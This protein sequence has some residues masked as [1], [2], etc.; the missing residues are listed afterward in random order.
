MIRASLLVTGA[1]GFIGR[2]IAESFFQ[3]GHRVV[4]C[5]RPRVPYSPT[6][7]S[8]VCRVQFPDADFRYLI[9]D[10]QP[11]WLIHCAG[12]ASVAAS[13]KNPAQDWQ[14]NVAATASLYGQV[15]R[16]SPKTRIIFLSSAA[17]YGQPSVFPIT[18]S[19]AVV[20]ISPYGHHKRTCEIL[21]EAL[22]DVAGI[23]VTNL[24][25]F[26]AYGAGLE[27][28]VLWDIYQKARRSSTVMLEGD[29]TETRD[30]I[31]VDDIVGIIHHLI[32]ND[33]RAF[34]VLNIASGASIEI[35]KLAERFLK[36]LGLQREVRFSGQRSPGVPANWS[37]DTTRLQGLFDTPPLELSIG[38]SKYADWLRYREGGEDAS[39][40]LAAAG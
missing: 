39:R 23:E 13:V 36:A 3:Q 25:I 4:A 28:Q 24:R 29:G 22:S 20:P 17:V 11:A 1:G 5:V 33:S 26:S 18:E 19:T 21:G 12:S 14:S 7:A 37:V 34:K 31:H 27:K 16:Y 35:A 40:V 8:R 15:A 9:A 10:E 38:L 2:A 30:L 6:V 32:L